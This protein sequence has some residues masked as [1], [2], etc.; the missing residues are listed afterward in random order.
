[1]ASDSSWGPVNRLRRSSWSSWAATVGERRFDLGLLGVV[2]LLAGELVE[3]LGVRQRL[4]EGVV[5]GDVV[6]EVGVLGVQ[7]LGVLGV[8]PQVRRVTSPPRPR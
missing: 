1:M 7:R 8:V 4:I 2:A 3:H 6:A 5:G